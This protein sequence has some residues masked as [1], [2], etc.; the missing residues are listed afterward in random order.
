MARRTEIAAPADVAELEVLR[1]CIELTGQVDLGVEDDLWEAGLESLDAVILCDTLSDAG[2]GVLEPGDLVEARTVRDVRRLLGRSAPPAS[3]VVTFHADGTREPQF[4]V[5]PGGGTA[6]AFVHLAAA[7]G[8]DQPLHVVE[9]RGLHR[10]GPVDRTIEDLAAHVHTAI[11]ER[12][13]PDARCALIAYSSGVPIGFEAAR[14]LRADGRDV[15]LV[16]LD[17]G[18]ECPFGN[19]VAGSRGTA[20]TPVAPRTVSRWLRARQARGGIRPLALGVD[21][22]RA[23]RSR[24]RSEHDVRRLRSLVADPGPPDLDPLRYEAFLE[25]TLAAWSE[26]HPGPLDAPVLH[27]RSAEARDSR[28]DPT[29]VPRCETVVAG[30]DHA[31]VIRPPAVDAVAAATARFLAGDSTAPDQEHAAVHDGPS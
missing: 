8:P 22:V 9:A 10:P 5:P 11:A 21:A 18:P 12:R 17:A 25:I 15:A 4:L 20:D 13:R 24:N 30:T 27:V 3:T 7:F 28:P 6:L 19:H 29:L 23:L 2:W 14:R 16:M 1:S 26:H 31:S